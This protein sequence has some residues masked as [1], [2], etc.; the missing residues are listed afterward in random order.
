MSIHQLCAQ[1]PWGTDEGFRFLQTG[2]IDSCEPLYEHQ[3][4][5]QGPGR[6]VSALTTEPSLQLLA[7]SRLF[8]R[9]K[10]VLSIR[11]V[12]PQW[13]TLVIPALGMGGRLQQD[14]YEL[15]ASLSYKV[16]CRP[17]CTMVYDPISK[18]LKLISQTLFMFLM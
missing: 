3:E 15:E 17:T 12:C 16:S 10:S 8:E 1:C 14:C 18:N 6:V 5:N 11:P 9:V 7:F 13:L 4:L 2:I